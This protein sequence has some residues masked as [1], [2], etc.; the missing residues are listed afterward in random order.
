MQDTDLDGGSWQTERPDNTPT[1]EET[2]KRQGHSLPLERH[3]DA[4]GWTRGQLPWTREKNPNFA[5]FPS[6]GV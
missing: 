2:G 4:P 6:G 5:W 3:T 1:T